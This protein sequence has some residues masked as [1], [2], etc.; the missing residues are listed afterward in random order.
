MRIAFLILLSA[1]LVNLELPN[2]KC[3]DD[4]KRVAAA[5]DARLEDITAL[6][7]QAGGEPAV[8][9][10]LDDF[11]PAWWKDEAAARREAYAPIDDVEHLPEWHDIDLL[12]RTV[13]GEARG[14]GDEEVRAVAHIAINRWLSRK[15]GDELGEV[16]QWPAQFSVWNVGDANHRVVT[17]ASVA[18]RP[19]WLRVSR[20]T[21][22]V[23]E[24]R[25]SGGADPTR[26]CRYYWHPK[27]MSPAG[28][29]P[30]W[31]QG[32]VPRAIGDLRCLRRAGNR[33]PSD[34]EG[35]GPT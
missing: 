9:E 32:L 2:L 8:G 5:C 13:F 35:S 26:G 3:A 15:W 1:I 4:S 31:A 23:L 22:Q 28:A 29:T 21:L 30:Y 19:G 14:Q 18:K 6:L 12:T 10:N 24:E 17:D 34:R 11:I 33:T 16:V 20:L 7:D 27:A 25:L